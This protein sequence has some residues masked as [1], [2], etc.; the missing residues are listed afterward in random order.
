MNQG[1]SAN[2]KGSRHEKNVEEILRP[3]FDVSMPY[4]KW[5]SKRVILKGILL[6]NAPYDKSLN[7]TGLGKTEFLLLTRAGKA[8]R[9]ECK[10]QNG[11]GSVMDKWHCAIFHAFL[12]MPEDCIVFVVAGLE[13][14]DVMINKIKTVIDVFRNW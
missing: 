8:I 11:G 13:Y 10:V 6:K 1:I 12:H 7:R 2:I 4:K 5:I 9:F 14:D 3:Y